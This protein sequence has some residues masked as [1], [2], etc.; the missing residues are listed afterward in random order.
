MLAMPH[1]MLPC[2]HIAPRRGGSR[3]I[4][5]GVHNVHDCRK[6]F[7]SG[8]AT[9]KGSAKRSIEVWKKI[10]HLHFS[11]VFIGSRSTFVVYTALLTGRLSL[12]DV[13]EL[14]RA[15]PLSVAMVI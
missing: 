13:L 4:E 5:G 3:N 11:V 2:P 10:F 7:C 15:R 12:S 6:Q 1:T 14:A 8:T 9:G